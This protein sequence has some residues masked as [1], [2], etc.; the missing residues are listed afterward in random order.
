VLQTSQKVRQDQFTKN[1]HF[2]KISTSVVV[3]DPVKYPNTSYFENSVSQQILKV[4]PL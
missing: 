2:V 4:S 3:E 1:A